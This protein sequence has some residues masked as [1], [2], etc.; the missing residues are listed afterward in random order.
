MPGFFVLADLALAYTTLSRNGRAFLRKQRS[1]TKARRAPGSI[2]LLKDRSSRLSLIRSL[3]ICDAVFTATVPETAGAAS[4]RRASELYLRFVPFA[5]IIL[6]IWRRLLAAYGLS[7]D[8]DD[9]RL[10]V[11]LNFVHREWN[12]LADE[13]PPEVLYDSLRSTEPPEPRF[14]LLGH[15]TIAHNGLAQRKGRLERQFQVWQ[16]SMAFYDRPFK[17]DEAVSYLEGKAALGEESYAAAVLPEVPPGL[18]EALR[19]L[20]IWL[21]ALD[22]ASDIERDRALGRS[23][24]MT[25]AEDPVEEIRRYFRNC[26][27][28][29]RRTAPGDPEP[30]LMLMRSL[31]A[32]VEAA[33]RQG[34]DIEGDF[35]AAR[36]TPINRISDPSSPYRA[37]KA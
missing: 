3:K 21:L 20:Y 24:S 35:Y 6:E 22:D 18:V 34:S 25:L 11:L 2:E 15:L 13:V 1:R 9:L 5:W 26:E 7:P 32:D 27:E 23:T 29:I 31:T 28:E 16:K 30:L 37:G 10:L 14:R 36:G 4:G 33:V 17:P 12:D 8:E 19:R